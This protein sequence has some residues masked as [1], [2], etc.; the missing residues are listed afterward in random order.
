MTQSANRPTVGNGD[1][2]ANPSVYVYVA[3]L[4]FLFMSPGNLVS[5]PLQF[6]YKD[7]LHLNPAQTAIFKL[8]INA[9]GFVA[10]L[11][12]ICRDRFNP[13]RMGDRGFILVFGSLSGLVFIGIAQVPLTV[14]AL[15]IGLILWGVA[16]GL[17]GAAY[18]AIMRNV[19]EARMMSGRM[20]TVY[21]LLSSGI[22]MLALYGGGWLTSLLPWHSLLILIGCAYLCLGLIALW[23][24][25]GVFLGASH[26]ESRSLSQMS[27]DLKLLLRHRGF[28]ISVTIWGLW[29]F[30]PSG[31]TPLMFYLTDTLRM[32]PVQ[33][34]TF[35]AIFNGAALP[36]ILL[37]G[38]LCKRISL[39][40]L[41]IVS[42]LIGIPQWMGVMF[43]GS[44]TQSYVVAAVMGLVGG[45]ASTAYYG[46][47]F[48]ACP[49][50]LAG[51]GMLIAS[52]LALIV[53]EVGNVMG[54][55][56]FQRWGFVGC[57]L[58]TTFAY[59]FLLPLCFLL[60]RNLVQP[61]DDE[62]VPSAVELVA[63]QD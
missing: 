48:R 32:S 30:S 7:Q 1:L 35:N 50:E 53:I 5:T 59:L 4:S 49:R 15:A 19:A 33:Y 26:A 16:I 11:F 12:G 46:L 18:Q 63:S 54:G 60:P 47:L 28:W 17:V 56:I 20:S 42:T 39:W 58:V 13:L 14:V 21:N 10:F 43:I 34:S 29:S 27:Q 40:K 3:A 45:L 57:A 24:P 38:F 8:I 25:P 62:Y 31:P 51:T 44:P 22:P 37:F 6:V 55:F 41:L 2:H 9:P 23:N 61:Q 36:T 52:S